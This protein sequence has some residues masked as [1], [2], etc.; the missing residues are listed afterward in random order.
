[1]CSLCR[2]NGFSSF[3]VNKSTCPFNIKSKNINYLKHNLKNIESLTKKD[4]LLVNKCVD[5]P[6]LNY[7]FNLYNKIKISYIDLLKQHHNINAS[8]LLF[9]KFKKNIVDG[10]KNI[11]LSILELEELKQKKLD[12]T[13]YNYKIIVD[14]IQ[15]L[16]RLLNLW[17]EGNR[18][19]IISYTKNIFE[20]CYNN[21]LL[22]ILP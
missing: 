12:F 17:L 6:N 20:V 1:M 7:C 21:Y 19:N 8:M 11:H 15:D 4:S 10:K 9:K 2:E 16:N 13:I 5:S 18:D 22:N 3:K 14:R